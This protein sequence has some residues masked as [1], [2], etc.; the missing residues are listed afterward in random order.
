MMGMPG[1]TSHREQALGMTPADRI[2]TTQ[3][4]SVALG[5]M[6]AAMATQ[7]PAARLRALDQAVVRLGRKGVPSELHH[8]LLLSLKQALL[9]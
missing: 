6:V 4:L 7:P 9:L 3:A 2:M 1:R 8:H 5:T